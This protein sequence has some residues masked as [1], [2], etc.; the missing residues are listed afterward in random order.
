MLNNKFNVSIAALAA[1]VLVAA[2]FVATPVVNDWMIS[3]AGLMILA[4][5]WNMAANAG[6]ISLGHS[7]FWGVGAYAALLVADK[8]KLPML[9]SLVPAILV[10]AVLGAGLAVITGRL[11]GIFF[12]IAT[13][14]LSEGLRVLALMAPKFTGGGEGMYVLQNLRPQP[15]MITAVMVAGALAC[16]FISWAVSRSRYQYVMRAMRA[17]ESAS[18]MLGVNPLYF[19]VFVLALSGA[20]TSFAGGV[21]VWYGGFLDPLIA[22]DLHI[23]IL[24]QIAPILGGIHTLVGP[25]IGALLASSLAESTR[26]L[27]GA[28]GLSVL[29]YGAVMIFGILYMPQGVWGACRASWLRIG[30]RRREV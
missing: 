4:V 26:I 2:P 25:V 21:K 29:V 17:N 6:L 12:A 5:S 16:I 11:R 20:M 13:L 9:V 15:K 19:R 28:K 18:Q 7:A 3:T 10:G 14:A 30:G 8:L 23:T 24:A 27:L 1:A 22:F